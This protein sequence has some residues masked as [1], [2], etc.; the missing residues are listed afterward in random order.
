MLAGS[1]SIVVR[2]G[3]VWAWLVHNLMLLGLIGMVQELSQLVNIEILF[4]HLIS[5]VTMDCLC[6]SLLSVME[7]LSE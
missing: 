4:F 3:L 2:Y 1:K 6:K 7:P 5:C